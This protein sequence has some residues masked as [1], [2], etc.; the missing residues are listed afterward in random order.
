LT[1]GDDVAD[2]PVT[3]MDV[4]RRARDG[5][6]S[7]ADLVAVLLTWQFEPQHRSRG[8][9]D[10]WEFRSNSFDAVQ[11]AYNLDLLDEDAYRR[12]ADRAEW[13]GAAGRE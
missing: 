11:F 4:V 10:D 5:E 1:D 13:S 8:L 2:A 6:I 7:G 9:T 3:A 12:I